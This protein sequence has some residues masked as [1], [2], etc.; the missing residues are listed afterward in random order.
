MP[1]RQR[2]SAPSEPTASSWDRGAQPSW[3]SWTQGAGCLNWLPPEMLSERAARNLAIAQKFYD[4]YHLSV[5]RGELR[6]VFDPA[7]SAETWI[8]FGPYI[9]AEMTHTH[10]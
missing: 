3:G 4:G 5:E 7:D 9:G 6:D 8:F 2:P 10:A 1:T